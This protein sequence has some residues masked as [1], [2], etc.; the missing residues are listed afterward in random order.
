MHVL[1]FQDPI[2]SVAIDSYMRVSDNGRETIN[3]KVCIL[4]FLIF[5]FKAMISCIQHRYR[6]KHAH[7]QRA[8][9]AS[10]LGQDGWKALV[11]T[12]G[13]R[14]MS[15]HIILTLGIRSSKLDQPLNKIHIIYICKYICIC[16]FGGMNWCDKRL[17]LSGSCSKPTMILT[18]SCPIFQLHYC[19]TVS[20]NWISLTVG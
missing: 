3:R 13:G 7:T 18:I 20:N 11:W 16:I 2:R 15:S 1:I 17:N 10:I 5:H 6:H 14:K 8:E 4:L 19:P 12:R 9:C